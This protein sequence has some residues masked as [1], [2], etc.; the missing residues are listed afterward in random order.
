MD[1]LNIVMSDLFWVRTAQK[2]VGFLFKTMLI[3]MSIDRSGFKP[4]EVNACLVSALCQEVCGH[5]HQSHHSSVSFVIYLLPVFSLWHLLGYCLLLETHL[6]TTTHSQNT[7]NF[8]ETRLWD[9]LW[10]KS[11]RPQ[12]F[13]RFTTAI[14]LTSTCHFLH[15][16]L[17]VLF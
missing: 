10:K 6:H 16:L 12:P 1:V 15:I 4:E 14:S 2:Q 11:C 8:R 17:D 7:H 3:T 5:F 13:S 9:L